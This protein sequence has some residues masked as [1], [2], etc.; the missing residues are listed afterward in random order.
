MSPRARHHW[1]VAGAVSGATLVLGSLGMLTNGVI[2][3]NE[4]AGHATADRDSLY[5]YVVRIHLSDSLQNR[6]LGRLERI[7]GFH[8][9]PF[10]FVGPPPPPQNTEGL[11]RRVFHLLF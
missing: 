6:R 4:K 1:T 10:A 8:A 7:G 9:Q 2:A 3:L 11:V 5:R